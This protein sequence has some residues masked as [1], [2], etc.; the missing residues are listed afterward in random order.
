MCI[1]EC[2]HTYFVGDSKP[3]STQIKK[4][5]QAFYYSSIF[6]N[7]TRFNIDF[8]ISAYFWAVSS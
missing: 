1:L 2:G 3:Q 7:T 5:I 8:N 6:E 4:C